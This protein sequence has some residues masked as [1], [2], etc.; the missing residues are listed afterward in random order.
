M[1]SETG[2]AFRTIAEYVF[3]TPNLNMPFNVSDFQVTKE[4]SGVPSRAEMA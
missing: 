3:S 4:E 2:D 1:G